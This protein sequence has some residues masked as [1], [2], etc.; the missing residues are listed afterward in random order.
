MTLQ[1]VIIQ[2]EDTQL[3]YMHLYAALVTELM[4][5]K[6]GQ[7]NVTITMAGILRS[8]NMVCHRVHDNH[9]LY[10]LFVRNNPEHHITLIVNL[11]VEE[12]YSDEVDGEVQILERKSIVTLVKIDVE[13][14][15]EQV[16]DLSIVP[17]VGSGDISI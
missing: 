11:E 17:Y 9:L 2:H 15:E 7:R 12:D 14:I 13:N 8:T 6:E 16:Q 5:V 10:N 1:D 4:H 3:D